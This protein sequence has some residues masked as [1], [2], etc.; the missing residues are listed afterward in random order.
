MSAQPSAAA[1]RV[2]PGCTLM[3]DHVCTLERPK[4]PAPSADD[5]RIHRELVAEHLRRKFG[6]T[7]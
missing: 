1:C 3:G 2:T 7:L 4:R 6:L 5:Q